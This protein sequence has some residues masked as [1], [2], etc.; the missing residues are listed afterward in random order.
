LHDLGL[1]P[2][3]RE[4][5]ELAAAH[6]SDDEI[7]HRLSISRKTVGAHLQSVFRKLSIGSRKQIAARLGID[8]LGRGFPIPATGEHGWTGA[9]PADPKPVPDDVASTVLA[10]FHQGIVSGPP[11]IWGSRLPI[12]LM[13]TFL[14]LV[15]LACASGLA[16]VVYHSGDQVGQ[17]VYAN[18][19]ETA[20]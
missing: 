13:W 17:G 8:S 2:R 18:S 1:T 4:V 9:V 11:K 16:L 5:A 7:A 20:Q 19:Q 15:A 3:E 10:R 14:G 6:L 12:I